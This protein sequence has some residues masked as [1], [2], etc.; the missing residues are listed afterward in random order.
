M[1]ELGVKAPVKLMLKVTLLFGPA[2]KLT[3]VVARGC[4]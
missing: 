4:S 3:K 2:A 1:G